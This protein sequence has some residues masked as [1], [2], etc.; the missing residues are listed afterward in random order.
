MAAMN[1][2]FSSL[3]GSLGGLVAA[4]LGVVLGRLLTIT[5]TRWLG[6]RSRL[7]RFVELVAVAAA[8]GLWWWEVPAGRLTPLA[9]DGSLFEVQPTILLARW[10]GHL[11]FFTLLAAATW[12]DMR[13]RVIPDWI[14]VTGVVLGL[15]VA[16]LLPEPFLPVGWEVE[17]SFAPPAILPDVLAAFGGLRS[18]PGPAW[19]GG[20]PH[21]GGLAVAGLIFFTWWFFCTAPFIE[22]ESS[23]RSSP[24][25][26]VALEP[27]NMVLVA[28]LGGIVVVWFIG[29]HRFDAL[30]AGLIGLAVAAGLVWGV[31]EGASRAM[32]REAM[33]FGDV[34]LMAM[35]G[36]WLGWQ[37]SV[38]VF[39]LATFLGLAHGL[40]GL[41]LH[42]DNE[43]PYGPSLCLA[44]VLVVVGW[45]PLWAAVGGYF[46]DPVLLAIMLV[47]VV[48]LTAAALWVWQWVRNAR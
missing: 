4:V 44:T 34:T 20:M 8:M 13:Y 46:A 1:D 7:E 42:R 28:G 48:V 3:T 11:V 32:G 24:L 23:G 35:I 16:C 14:T 25:P 43:L 5:V 21:I 38:I 9:A 19:M 17:R 40:L 15:V 45:R 29:G 39:F 47:A 33:G 31:R 22:A 27:R 26:R 36:A 37:P 41:L 10:A 18:T 2:P 30:Q 12:I 6:E